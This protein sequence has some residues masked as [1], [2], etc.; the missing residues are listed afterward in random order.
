MKFIKL[1]IRREYSNGR[2][3]FYYPKEY[4]SAKI[5][6]GPF[7][8]STHPENE[9]KVIKRGDWE[10]II[11]GVD[12]KYAKRLLGCPD[13]E[14]ISEEKAKKLGEEWLPQHEV[15]KDSRRVLA[16]LAKHVRGQILTREEI[17]ALTPE[18][19]EPGINLSPSIEELLYR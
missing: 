8:E 11:I 16:I 4:E 18:H 14:E 13:T 10:Y 12:E 9:K 2:T 3:R 19:P 6:V 17:N 5:K 1:K 15:I 7:Y